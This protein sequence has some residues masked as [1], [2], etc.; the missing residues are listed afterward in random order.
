MNYQLTCSLQ[1]P[2]PN[3]KGLYFKKAGIPAIIV[4][5]CDGHDDG[6]EEDVLR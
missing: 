4:I 1:E 5:T 3:P 2:Y 6:I